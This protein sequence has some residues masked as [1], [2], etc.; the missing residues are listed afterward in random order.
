MLSRVL[1]HEPTL[2]GWPRLRARVGG[3]L[4]EALAEAAL[5]TASP[6]DAAI[7]ASARNLDAHGLIVRRATAVDFEAIIDV[8]ARANAASLSEVFD[9][10]HPLPQELI[11]S[12]WRT[13]LTR[14][15]FRFAVCTDGGTI[16]GVSQVGGSWFHALQVAPEYWG[17]GVAA[18]LHDE[19]LDAIRASGERRVLARVM[20]GNHR[21]RAFW[22]KHGWILLPWRPTLSHY[23]PHPRV[24]TYARLLDTTPPRRSQA[25]AGQA[26]LKLRGSL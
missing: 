25:L 17:S 19:A 3:T 15:N 14:D 9:E 22:T 26:L 21:A 13:A 2:P 23:P 11:A 16:V 8:Q 5:S 4:K 24:L 18:L 6:P 12:R 1:P 7:E 10:E 20:E